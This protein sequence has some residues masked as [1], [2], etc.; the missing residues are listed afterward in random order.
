MGK[1]KKEQDS[2]FVPPPTILMTDT[3]TTL[4][5]HTQE[6]SGKEMSPDALMVVYDFGATLVKKAGRMLLRAAYVRD[7]NPDVEDEVKG[8][9]FAV[10]A[11]DGS[12]IGE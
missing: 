6:D 2:V 11:L 12:G 7:D 4:A 1:E 5:G 9:S 3:T 10:A 8:L